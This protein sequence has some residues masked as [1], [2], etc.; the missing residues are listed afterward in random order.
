M[1]QNVQS[2][3]LELIGK[4]VDVVRPQRPAASIIRGAR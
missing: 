1:M 4:A 2:A 3:H